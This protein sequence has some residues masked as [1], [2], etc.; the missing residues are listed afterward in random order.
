[1]EP[2]PDQYSEK[3]TNEEQQSQDLQKAVD[4]AQDMLLR[5]ESTFPF[6]LF[7]DTISISRMKVTLTR[8]SFFRVAEVISLQIGDILNVEA[9]VGPFFGSLSIF[10]RIYGA[11]PLK[12]AFLSRKSTIDAQRIIEGFMIAKDKNIE[13]SDIKTPDLIQLL[14]RLGG[15]TRSAP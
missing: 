1:M 3:P 9:D 11:D 12:I 10:T 13:I 14:T 7:P 2:T 6:V 15:D 5:A 4:Y 8:R